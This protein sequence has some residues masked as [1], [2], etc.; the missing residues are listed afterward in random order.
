MEWVETTDLKDPTKGICEYSLYL[1]WLGHSPRDM[2]PC[3]T[4][5]KE[6]DGTWYSD[7]W[8]G[9]TGRG[10]G[11][12]CRTESEAKEQ[13]ILRLERMYESIGKMLDRDGNGCD[14]W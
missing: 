13:C 9:N 11:K 10:I 5:R 14:H 7:F 3:F 8:H 12:P 4:V 1:P 2:M 6:I